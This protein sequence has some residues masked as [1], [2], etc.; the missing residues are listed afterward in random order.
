MHKKSFCLISCFFRDTIFNFVINQNFRPLFVVSR[1]DA[2]WLFLFWSSLSSFAELFKDHWSVQVYN[3]CICIFSAR[4]HRF[5]P[6]WSLV[7]ILSYHNA[8]WDIYQTTHFYLPNWCT[9][10]NIPDQ[11]SCLGAQCHPFSQGGLHY[12][13]FLVGLCFLATQGGPVI[14]GFRYPLYFL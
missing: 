10:G 9:E 2:C 11:E 13:N 1:V 7:R 3:K 6:D 4:E 8:P 12:P 5:F 14:H